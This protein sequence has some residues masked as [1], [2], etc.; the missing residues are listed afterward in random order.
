MHFLDQDPFLTGQCASFFNTNYILI[1]KCSIFAKPPTILRPSE[2]HSEQ[3]AIEIAVTKL[4]LRSYYDIV[5]KNIEDCVP[6]AIMHF[7]VILNLRILV[8]LFYVLS[9]C[10]FHFPSCFW[11]FTRFWCII[12]TLSSW[13]VFRDFNCLR[14]QQL[15]CI[16]AYS[17]QLS[18][19]LKHCV[20]LHNV[21][22]LNFSK[23]ALFYVLFFQFFLKKFH[24]EVLL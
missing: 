21:Y 6:K 3:E 13:S 14:K 18:L 17:T 23:L 15:L 19:C 1:S 2:S 11:H 4:L 16:T 8:P 20:Q 9:F 10:C 22:S 7:L 5:R 24:L 12:L